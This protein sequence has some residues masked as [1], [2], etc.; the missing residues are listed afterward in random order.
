M[1]AKSPEALAR[2]K[3]RFNE[4]RRAKRIAASQP[5]QTVT[6]PHRKWRIGP[7]V[8][9]SKREMADMLAQAVRNTI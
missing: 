9:M 2:K 1:P 8:V 5:V 6:S 7:E 4:R 3:Q